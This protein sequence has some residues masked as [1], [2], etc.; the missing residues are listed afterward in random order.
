MTLKQDTRKRLRAIGHN[1]DPVVTVAAKG[2]SDG[3]IAEIDR[4]LSDHE[5]IKVRLTVGDRALKK[6]LI[7]EIRQRLGAEQVQV[8]GHVLLL[9]RKAEQPDPRLSNLLRPT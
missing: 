9:Y 2:L 3:V 8:I 4:A 6:R 5:L 1:L 7:S